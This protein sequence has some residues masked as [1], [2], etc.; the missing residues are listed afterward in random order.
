MIILYG[1]QKGGCGKSTGA[2]N[3]CVELATHGR[4]IVL[5]DADIQSTCARW[6]SDREENEHTPVVPCIQ[7]YGN[8]RNTLL[9]LDQRYE[10]VI[11]DSAGR[12]SREL[13]TGMLA[14]HIMI[15]PFRPSQPDLDTLPHLQEVILQALDLNPKLKIYGLI[16]MGPTHYRNSEMSEA[17]EYL[18][19]FPEITPLKTVIYDRKA[20]RDAMSEGLSVIELSDDKAK[21]EVKA[22]R[23]ELIPW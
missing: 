2:V 23:E 7:K 15:V 12:D 16:S 8:L 1:S 11:V 17:R 9:D 5:V 22:L 21:S 13:R 6:A 14:A 10:F 4:D 18:T 19:D 3:L 20:Y